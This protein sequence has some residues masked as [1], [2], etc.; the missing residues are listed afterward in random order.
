MIKPIRV[1]LVEDSAADGELIA[2]QLVTAGLGGTVQRVDSRDTF[3]AALREFGPDVVLCDHSLASFNARAAM[4]LM[5]AIRPGVPLIVVTGN[6]D[7][8]LAVESMR[9]GAEDVLLK[10]HLNRLPAAIVS[11][12]AARQRLGALSPR[13]LEVLRLIAEGHSTPEIARRLSLSAKTV[14]THRTEL[15]RRLG[16]HEVATLVRFAVRVGLVSSE[17]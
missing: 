8:H 9:I 10:S 13:Q 12:L 15:M 7:E 6:D 17:P 5:R 4:E 16:I 11:A 3:E 2:A 1:L 14:E